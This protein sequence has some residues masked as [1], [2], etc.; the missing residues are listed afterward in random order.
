MNFNNFTFSF[1]NCI[2]KKGNTTVPYWAVASRTRSKSLKNSSSD[3]EFLAFVSS[4]VPKPKPQK[5]SD[6]SS[7]SS[8]S[9][10]STIIRMRGDSPQS[11]DSVVPGSTSSSESSTDIQCPSQ[12]LL[13]QDQVED[14]EVAEVI[15]ISSESDS[16]DA[17]PGF[18]Q[19]V[20]TDLQVSIFNYGLQRSQIF[21]T[22]WHLFTI[23]QNISLLSFS[24]S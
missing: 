14:H 20:N 23:T 4:L 2:I 10:C 16:I 1:R 6:I 15:T 19:S 9:G 11:P 24:V 7:V 13:Y 18:T 8:S 5:S 22:F 17:L 12:D 3:E 21:L